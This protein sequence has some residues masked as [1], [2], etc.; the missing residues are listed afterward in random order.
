MKVFYKNN[1]NCNP[2]GKIDR[3]EKYFSIKKSLFS[4]FL[5]QEKNNVIKKGV[6]KLKQGKGSFDKGGRNSQGTI[7]VSHRGGRNKRLYR[8]IDFKRV[9]FN[10][11]PSFPLE[12]ENNQNVIGSFK[13]D[14]KDRMDLS[15][16]GTVIKIEYDPNRTAKIAL[17][18]YTNGLLSYILCPKD[19]KVGD[20]VSSGKVVTLSKGN[21]SPIQ[22]IPV[23]TL[24]HNIELKPGKGGQ[25][26]RAA[27]TYAK[28]IKKEKNNVIVKLKSG[29]LYNIPAECMATIGIVSN[30]L[31]KN[32][33]LNKA[34]NNRWKGKR[35]TVR[36]VAMNPVD[37]PHGGGEGR[38][39]GGRHPV[40]P[41]GKLTKGKPTSFLKKTTNRKL[42]RKL[43]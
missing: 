26:V 21:A 34:G 32:K 28:I 31:N 19:L 13:I 22:N 37:H 36:G 24:I 10:S 14:N 25:L 1:H 35:P 15:V 23:G 9:L 27:G 38:S 33:K 43:G 30:E 39:K 6:K 11:I 7:T 42:K 20:K 40:T 18:F 5:I 3:K 8:L 17:I 2:Y 16:E 41:W 12:T 29:K 4:S